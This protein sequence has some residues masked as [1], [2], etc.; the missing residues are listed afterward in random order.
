MTRI[1]TA[2]HEKARR[3][4]GRFIRQYSTGDEIDSQTF[5]DVIY[6]LNT[7]LAY[8]KHDSDLRIEGRLDTIEDAIK[9]K[10]T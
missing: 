2:T 8:F 6:G 4:L 9:E 7:L 3:S 1:N 5:R 10:T